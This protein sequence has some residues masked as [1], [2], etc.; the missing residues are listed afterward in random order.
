MQLGVGLALG[1]IA[2]WSV[3]SVVGSLLVQVAPTDPA[4]FISAAAL[5]IVVTLSACLIPA[6]RAT[7]LDPVSALRAD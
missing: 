6:A 2:A 7:R 4:T 5:L 1:L 3:S